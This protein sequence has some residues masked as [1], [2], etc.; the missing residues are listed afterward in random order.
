MY[1]VY[2][3]LACGSLTGRI[4]RLAFCTAIDS[5]PI[6]RDFGLPNYSR[7]ALFPNST[8][9]SIH[10]RNASRAMCWPSI[11]QWIQSDMRWLCCSKWCK[12]HSL[13]WWHSQRLQ[14]HE[15]WNWKLVKK[16]IRSMFHGM[17]DLW[18]MVQCETWSGSQCSR[19]VPSTFPWRTTECHTTLASTNTAAKRL[20]RRCDSRD[21]E[22]ATHC[23]F[24]WHILDKIVKI[25]FSISN[26][27]VRL[28]SSSD[29]DRRRS[30][31]VAPLHSS[32]FRHFGTSANLN[33]RALT[34]TSCHLNLRIAR[35]SDPK[36]LRTLSDPKSKRRLKCS[37]NVRS[38]KQTECHS[39]DIIQ[40]IEEIFN[41]FRCATTSPHN[42]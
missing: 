35:T 36:S 30:D 31:I 32:L 34:R 33:T 11:S 1:C 41:N 13:Q 38:I 4:H 42:T 21:K 18:T 23:P 39:C 37:T 7:C 3:S 24:Q 20:H 14:T 19:I 17:E 10:C 27:R 16:N 8:A 25:L 6:Q 29:W 2:V 5:V 15:T 12:W 28:F 9:Y 22:S 40:W 26:G